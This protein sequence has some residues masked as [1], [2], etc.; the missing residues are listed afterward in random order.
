MTKKHSGASITHDLAGLGLSSRLVAVN[1]TV[2]AGWLIF[3]IGTFLQSQL[4]V[5]QEFLTRC[6]QNVVRIVMVSGAINTDHFG[7]GS[8]FTGKSF[9]FGAHC[10]LCRPGWS[11]QL[12]AVSIRSS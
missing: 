7:H 3:P 6:A 11:L 2:G 9:F 12:R 4:S 5:V 8:L 1:R 10:F